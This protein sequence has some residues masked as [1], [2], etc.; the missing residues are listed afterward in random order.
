M[1][2][3]VPEPA[4]EPASTVPWLACCSCSDTESRARLAGSA[5]AAVG[6][7]AGMTTTARFAGLSVV[8]PPAGFSCRYPAWAKPP[9]ML[10]AWLPDSPGCRC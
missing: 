10:F 2:L 7:V 4:S 9:R 6:A 3:P 5:S 8:A 1:A